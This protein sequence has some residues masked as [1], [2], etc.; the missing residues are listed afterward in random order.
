MLVLGGKMSEKRLITETEPLQMVLGLQR[1][2][3]IALPPQWCVR[4]QGTRGEGACER[5]KRPLA[6]SEPI[7]ELDRGI[8]LLSAVY[9]LASLWYFVVATWLDQGTRLACA[10]PRRHEPIPME[11]MFC[12]L[13]PNPTTFIYLFIFLCKARSLKA[14]AAVNFCLLGGVRTRCREGITMVLLL[15]ECFLCSG[16]LLSPFS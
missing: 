9:K 10:R 15:S 1:P 2:Q 5:E 4:T 12:C 7:G 13:L 8:C 11:L 14:E 3:T 16:P 6:D